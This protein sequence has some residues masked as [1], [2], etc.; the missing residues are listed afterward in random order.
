MLVSFAV[1]QV[2]FDL[3]HKHLLQDLLHLLAEVEG[4]CEVLSQA[5]QVVAFVDRDLTDP[6]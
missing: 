3:F 6:A 2:G 1:Q 4:H 5:L